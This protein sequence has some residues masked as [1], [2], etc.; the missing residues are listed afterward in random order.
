MGQQNHLILQNSDSFGNKVV[1]G[2]KNTAEVVS[3]GKH[4]MMWGRGCG[5]GFSMLG[6]SSPR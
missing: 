6:P 3:A 1:S 5:R 4:C 2:I